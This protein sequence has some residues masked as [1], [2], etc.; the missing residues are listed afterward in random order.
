M[1]ALKTGPAASLDSFFLPRSVAIIGAS[2]DPARIGGRP[3]RYL[4]E[5][6]FRGAVYPVNPNRA[7]V[8]G[9]KAY[10]RVEDLPEA[11]DLVLIAVPSA[12]VLAALGACG[13]RGAKAVIVFS[14]GFAETGEDGAALQDRV[15]AIARDHGMRLLGPNCLGAFNAETGFYG[16]FSQILDGSRPKP[17][18]VAIVSQS[19]AYGSHLAHLAGER[20]LG[21]RYFLTTGNE[22]DVDVAEGLLW[23]A[24]R[25]D[26]DVILAY[27]EGIK[28]PDIF[29]RALGLA[30]ENRKAVI[31]MKVG[32][33][34]VGAEAI[35]SHTAAL[36]GSDEIYDAVFRQFNVHRARTT[37]E[38]VDVAYACA[39]GIY[40]RHNRLG[41]F[42]LS[43][44]FG[45]QMADAAAE[46][47]LDVAPMPVEAQAELK[48]LLPYASPKNPVDA[49]AQALTDLDLMSRYLA[50]MLERGRYD[51]IV[52]IFGSGPA[53]PTFRE[54]LR[55]ALAAAIAD[56]PD[57]LLVLTVSAPRDIVR[58]YEDKGFLIF[59][60]G[61]SAITALAALIRIGHGFAT[62]PVAPPAVEEAA[63]DLSGR[64][65]SEN[66][67]KLLLGKAGIAFPREALAKDPE[68]A[69]GFAREIGWPVVLKIVSADI[70]HKTEIGGVLLDLA[71]E[72]AVRAGAALI[73]DRARQ[74]R[75][76]A[77]IDGVLV[78][79]MLKDGVET[80]IGV[81]RDPVFG[82]VVMFGLGGI[83]V[84]VLK[85]V[86]F[87][88]APFDK[89][90]ALRMIGEIKG[91]P[92]LEG[93]RGMKACDIDALAD[94]LVAVSVFAARHADDV[95]SLDLNPVLVR[96]AGQGAVALDALIV[97]APTPSGGQE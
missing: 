28:R 15:L 35:A 18:P 10:G 24:G 47:G 87:R 49:T 77:V 38:Q 41:I 27:A 34:A 53:S 6:G 26:V 11:A 57:R 5:S 16:T 69:V 97:T 94:M 4:R 95:T 52:G 62:V 12:H 39:R 31:F 60:D 92:M 46:A 48:A 45:I 43:G 44:G 23:L 36:A 82:P 40:P 58:A 14:A 79:P 1:D 88:V 17:G 56:F 51:A 3:L 30:R 91:Y 63:A 66:D 76:D 96:A 80:I 71:G 70:P 72:D 42:T 55:A 50:T 32:R 33:S 81:V 65:L 54:P 8:Q 84:E 22:V 9:L 19:G 13:E 85:D 37:A 61:H 29:L 2:D 74:A 67:A 78:A 93:V 86:T 64:Q 83:F 89:A 20:G 90:E 75:P 68:S 73:L 59:E 25:F 7:E 21:I